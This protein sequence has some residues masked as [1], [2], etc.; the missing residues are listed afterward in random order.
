MQ[1]VSV[2][3][4]SGSGKSTFARRLAL[5]IDAPYVELD[6]VHHQPGW[7]PIEPAEFLAWAEATAR[8]DRWVVDG[9]NRAVVVDGPIWR[10]ADTVVWLR[11]PRRTVMRR[12]VPRTLRRVLLRQEL[13]NGNRESFGN[14]YRWDPEHNVIRSAW[15]RHATYEQRF[16]A[17]RSDPRFA[18]LRFIELRSPA[19]VDTWLDGLTRR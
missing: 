10:R 5:I 11:L 4:G 18:H 2:V 6:A 7:T 15:V 3:G 9:N 8:T 14:L 19:E 16:T 1:R 12:I 17:A 13:W